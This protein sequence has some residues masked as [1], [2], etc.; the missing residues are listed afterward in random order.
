MSEGYRDECQSSWRTRPWKP[1]SSILPSCENPERDRT[2]FSRQFVSSRFRESSVRHRGG[3]SGNFILE[4]PRPG[5]TSINAPI[6]ILRAAAWT[7]LG[8]DPRHSFS[9]G[10]AGN[11]RV[12]LDA[13]R[14]RDIPPIFPLVSDKAMP[15]TRPLHPWPSRFLQDLA[16]S[17]VQL[18]W[19]SARSFRHAFRA[20]RTEDRGC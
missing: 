11:S 7:L 20:T 2:N 3:G 17:S 6:L 13:Q 5:L 14:A 10:R 19:L 4:Q 1:F 18:T 16:V 12:F 15:W 9:R 8:V